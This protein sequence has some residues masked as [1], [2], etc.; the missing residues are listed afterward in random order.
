MKRMIRF[1]LGGLAVGLSTL[2]LALPAVAHAGDAVVSRTY[3]WHSDRLTLEVPADVR[4]RPGATWHLT[5]SAPERTLRELV[6]KDGRIKVRSHACFSLIPFCIGFGRSVRDSVHVSLTGPALRA[7]NVDGAAKI[8]L[9]H[10]HQDRL[11]LRIDGSASVHGTGAVEDLAVR[12]DGAGSIHLGRMRA[13]QARVDINGSGTV[14][15]APTKR[16]T[17]RIDGVGNVRLHSNPPHVSSRIDGV[18]AVTRVS[19]G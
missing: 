2:V 10:V 3:P 8:R 17:V 6:V 7:I 18:G 5:I 19:A 11:A 15:I 1:A 16:V 9:D 12:I 13:Q 14:G 4:F